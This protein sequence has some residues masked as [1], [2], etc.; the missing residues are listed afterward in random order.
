MMKPQKTP[1][2]QGSESFQVSEEE[3]LHVP[4]Q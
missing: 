4:G 3:Y 2:G 1:K